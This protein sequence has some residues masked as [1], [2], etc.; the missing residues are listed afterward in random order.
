[1]KAY[2]AITDFSANQSKKYSFPVIET[3]EQ[4]NL[5]VN[6]ILVWLVS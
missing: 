5:N 3:N 4:T 6:I 1:M 2:Y